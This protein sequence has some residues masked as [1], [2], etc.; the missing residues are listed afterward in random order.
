MHDLRI[1]SRINGFS[2]KPRVNSKNTIKFLC[3][4]FLK[5]SNTDPQKVYNA[6]KAT[7]N[8][9]KKFLSCFPLDTCEWELGV[10]PDIFL[11]KI[12]TDLPYPST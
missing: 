6:K 7:P 2:L 4:N 9:S 12:E 8:L 11:D 5:I 10:G 3:Y 1:Q